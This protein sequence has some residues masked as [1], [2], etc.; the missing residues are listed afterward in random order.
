MK[1]GNFFLFCQIKPQRYKNVI[2]ETLKANKCNM[3]I[4]ENLSLLAPCRF[5]CFCRSQSRK[6]FLDQEST[7]DDASLIPVSEEKMIQR[8]F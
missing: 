1:Y 6:R 4:H 2:F 8:F 7:R 5:A 3:E